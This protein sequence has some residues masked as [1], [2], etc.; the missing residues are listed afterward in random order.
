MF[1]VVNG[2]ILTIGSR[3]IGQNSVGS[4]VHRSYVSR[5][6]KSED[7]TLENIIIVQQQLDFFRR[8]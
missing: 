2:P 7:K 3:C 4:E 6:K 1:I 5:C 8:L